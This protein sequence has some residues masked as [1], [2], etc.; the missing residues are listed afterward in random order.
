MNRLA[1]CIPLLILLSSTG[2]CTQNER[3]VSVSGGLIGLQGAVGGQ[4]GPSPPRTGAGFENLLTQ[5][6]DAESLDSL[7]EAGY[8]RLQDDD[9][10]IT[11]VSRSPSHV[12]F[13]LRETLVS[14]EV[15]LL[16]EQVLS[17]KTKQNYRSRGMDPKLAVEY[18]A[19]NRN[20]ILDF[21][22]TIPMGEKTPGVLQESL[23]RNMFRYRS[24]G[25]VAMGLKFSALDVIVEHKSFRL[26]MIN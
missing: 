5:E 1:R 3:V 10:N 7:S 18:M 8:L 4:A 2:S 12:V 15:D 24:G 14:E 20:A 23:G 16:F 17:E 22:A 21:L 19:R 26:L 13:H 9:G 25:A 11:L 6:G